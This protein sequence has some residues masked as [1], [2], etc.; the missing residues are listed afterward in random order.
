MSNLSKKEKKFALELVTS[1]IINH[2][3]EE[4]S[5]S[6]LNKLLKNGTISR[7]TFYNYKKKAYEKNHW[8]KPVKLDNL[9]SGSRQRIKS[10]DFPKYRLFETKDSRLADMIV[11]YTYFTDINNTT[12]HY[13]KLMNDA[14][15]LL[16]NSRNFLNGLDTSRQKAKANYKDVPEC[17]AIRKENINCD[18]YESHRCPHGPYY[19]AYW[20]S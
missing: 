13:G 8:R 14:N 7:R 20:R 12:Q 11:H 6:L 9:F 2:L 15:T 19:Y 1:C 18:R 16:E 5:F 3:N 17:A 10:I 4:E